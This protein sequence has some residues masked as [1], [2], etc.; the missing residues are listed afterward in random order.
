MASRSAI[1]SQPKVR[2]EAV[3]L[4]R[5]STEPGTETGKGW[6]DTTVKPE[7]FGNQAKFGELGGDS[8]GVLLG[9]VGDLLRLRL[10]LGQGL[11]VHFVGLGQLLGGRCTIG[12][13]GADRLLLLLHQRPNRRHHVLPDD[14]H[15]DREA[16]ELPD[17]CRH[18]LPS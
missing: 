18:L 1:R 4:E 11:G 8:L 2:G 12:K 16:D 7:A 9:F 14:E 5:L 6:H 15:D 17:E 3:R 13:R 10:R